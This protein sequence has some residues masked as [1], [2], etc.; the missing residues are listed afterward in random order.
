MGALSIAF[1]MKMQEE[2]ELRD[3]LK[4]LRKR[5]DQTDMQGKE[6][7]ELLAKIKSAERRQLEIAK[8]LNQKW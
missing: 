1:Q 3:Y 2:R 6:A 5:L 8:W 4:D 7:A